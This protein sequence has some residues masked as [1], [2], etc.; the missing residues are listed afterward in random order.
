[1][2]LKLN[3]NPDTEL[4]IRGAA[5]HLVETWGLNSLFALT[6]AEMIYW[7]FV[8]QL[9]PRITSGYRS[10]AHQERLRK[11]YRA[12]DPGVVYPPARTSKHCHTTKDGHPDALAID[13]ATDNPAQ[14]AMIAEFFGIRPGY[15]FKQP[16][17]VHYQEA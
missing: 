16:D 12:G 6:V 9:Q 7:F 17:P 10:V 3:Y 4:W 8:Y 5:E 11:R 14:A 13:I 15:H 1:M 2:L